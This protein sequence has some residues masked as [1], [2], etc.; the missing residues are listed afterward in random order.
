L[1]QFVVLESRNAAPCVLGISIL[2]N[3]IF[4]R[5]DRREMSW[6][7]RMSSFDMFLMKC[8]NRRCSSLDDF[9]NVRLRGAHNINF[10]NLSFGF[11]MVSQ[12]SGERRGHGQGV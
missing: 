8:G 1:C 7:Q 11:K 10:S 4:G 9:W 12:R 5:W 3:R 2:N 6:R